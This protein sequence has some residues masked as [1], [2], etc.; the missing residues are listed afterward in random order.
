MLR[1]L[2]SY[3]VVLSVL[4][5]MQLSSAVNSYHYVGAYEIALHE[6]FLYIENDSSDTQ[7][8]DFSLEYELDAY[9]DQYD[10]KSKIFQ[11][12]ILVDFSIQAI[13][14]APYQI[15]SVPFISKPDELHPPEPSPA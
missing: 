12:A 2:F 14:S 7:Y 6:A 4:V 5:S 8:E 10:E 15:K 13:Q 11:L 1:K 9:N 3:F